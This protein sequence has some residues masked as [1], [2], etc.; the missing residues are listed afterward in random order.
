MGDHYGFS[1]TTFSPSGKLMQIEYALNAV[2]NGQP[3]VGLRAKDG[4]VLATENK[5]SI[6]HDDET[7]IEKVS[8]HI[9]VVYSGMGPDFRLLVKRARKIAIQYELM[10]GEEIPTTELVSRL[11]AV[12]QEYTQS[13]GVRPFGVSLLIA[14]WDVVK[15]RPLL[16][17]SDPSGAFFAWKAT[18]LGKNDINAKTFLEK[19][20]NDGLELDDGIHTALLTL[21]ESF[22]VGMT[23][24]NVEIA[25]C[26]EAGFRRLTRQQIKDH[27]SAL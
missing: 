19:R 7:K 4:V 2:K 21:R 1:L 14:G 20:F 12:M 23:E 27:L 13:G 3:S 26:T 17:Q 15:K 8:E 10:F 22:D 18:A 16:F 25:V 9:G 5:S 11:A 6:L 24:E